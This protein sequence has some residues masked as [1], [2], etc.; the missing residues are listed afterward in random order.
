MK[1]ILLLLTI[2]FSITSGYSKKKELTPTWIKYPHEISD[3]ELVSYLFK[4]DFKLSDSVQSAEL[5]VAATGKF[6]AYVNGQYVIFGGEPTENQALP[7]LMVVRVDSFLQEGHN[8]IALELFPQMGDVI[9]NNRCFFELLVNNVVVKRSDKTVS[10]YADKAQEFCAEP[11]L[12]PCKFDATLTFADNWRMPRFD[13]R[14]FSVE[15]WYKA[16]QDIDFDSGSAAITNVTSSLSVDRAMNLNFPLVVKAGELINGEFS[17]EKNGLYRFTIEGPGNKE[18]LFTL[19]DINGLLIGKYLTYSGKQTF[20]VPYFTNSKSLSL[21]FPCAFKL[22]DVS[23][24]SF[25]NR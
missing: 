16:E 12:F 18:I 7:K 21:K 3:N 5:R 13:E 2:L 22:V 14:K 8:A 23:F 6:I 25:D 4:V 9:S 17:T 1:Q 15:K 20:V 24:L 19:N 10:C 11:V